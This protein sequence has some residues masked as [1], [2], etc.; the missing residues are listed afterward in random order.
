MSQPSNLTKT[1]RL[2]HTKRLNQNLNI[3]RRQKILRIQCF[4]DG[5]EMLR[6]SVVWNRFP[7]HTLKMMVTHSLLI[8][9]EKVI[10]ERGD[11]PVKHRTVVI[12]GYRPSPFVQV[13]TVCEEQCFDQI[14]LRYVS[15]SPL[16][17]GHDEVYAATMRTTLGF[18]STCSG[19]ALLITRTSMAAAYNRIYQISKI[20]EKK[21][22]ML[23]P[24]SGC[25]EFYGCDAAMPHDRFLPF[26][27][28][29]LVR[30][31]SLA[32]RS[33]LLVLA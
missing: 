29:A 13:G 27:P 31:P 24:C 5:E 12:V 19:I 10:G 11:R 6:R 21:V 8:S 23:W 9:F 28:A 16:G 3:A 4:I 1:Q 30:R 33:A 18:I 17:F 15:A 14:I 2:N 22:N 20:C 25:A 26:M 32:P 7:G